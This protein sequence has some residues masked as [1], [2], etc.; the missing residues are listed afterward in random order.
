MS[1]KDNKDVCQ[2]DALSEMYGDGWDYEKRFYQGIEA[3]KRE[4]V[5]KAA[6]AIFSKPSVRVLVRPADD[7]K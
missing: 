6:N 4:D 5:I 2:G 3:V 1:K 7:G